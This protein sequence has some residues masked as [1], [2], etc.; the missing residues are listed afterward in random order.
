MP[1]INPEHLLDQARNLLQVPAA[2]APRQADLRRAISTAYYAVFHLTMTAVA[3]ALIGNTKR[4]TSEYGLAYRAV[5]HR[6]LKA[7][8][9]DLQK[10]SLPPRVAAVAPAGGFGADFSVYAAAVVDLQEK[11][12]TADYDPLA[13]FALVD[14][15]LAVRTAEAAS[16]SF[17]ATSFGEKLAFASLLA[18]RGRA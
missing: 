18:F 9:E 16:A 11:R 2:G 3:D 4:S 17:G 5:D 15:K 8:C 1:V 10:P 12:H 14:A 7:L 13:K 6:S